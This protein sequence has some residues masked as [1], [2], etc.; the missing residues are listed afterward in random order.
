LITSFASIFLLFQKVNFAEE[1]II[2]NNCAN[3]I[4]RY[5]EQAAAIMD[6]NTADPAGD[7]NIQM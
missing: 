3:F 4:Y 5:V 1:V 7:F 2:V 6:T